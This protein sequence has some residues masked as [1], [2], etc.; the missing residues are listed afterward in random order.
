VNFV[1]DESVDQQIVERLRREGHIIQ[2]MVEIGPGTSDE[3]V[4]GL[5]RR[6]G[7]ILLTAD[8]DF[9]EMVF[10][11]RQITSGVLF[12]RGRPISRQKGRSC[13]FRPLKNMARSCREPSVS[14]H[15]AVFVSENPLIEPAIL[16]MRTGRLLP[17]IN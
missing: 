14:S 2:Y 10:R 8:K 11:Q 17:I 12:I 3:D 16:I 7:S 5:A 1:A 6:E 4:L 13:G 15:P 9:G